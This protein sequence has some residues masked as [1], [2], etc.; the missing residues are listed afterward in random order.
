MT[1]NNIFDSATGTPFSGREIYENVN[2]KIIGLYSGEGSVLDIGCGSGALG[3]WIKRENRQAVVHGVDISAEAGITAAERLDSFWC[4]D[5]DLSPLPETG[6]KYDLIIL[7]DI[8]EHLKR[9]DL[10]LSGLKDR[11]AANGKIIVSVPNVA[12]YS[13]RLRLLFGQFRYTETGIMDRTHLRFFTWHSFSELIDR[14]GFAIEKQSFISRFS[15]LLLH[16][17]FPLL[18]VQFIVKLKRR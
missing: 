13:I 18:A 4:V 5:L 6:L 9:P 7:G 12:N 16:L 17:F 3:A 10:F 14:S 8:L 15:G 11:L 2:P 1:I